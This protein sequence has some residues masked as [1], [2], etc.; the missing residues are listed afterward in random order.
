MRVLHIGWQPYLWLSWLSTILCS[1]V[2]GSHLLLLYIRSQ[3]ICQWTSLMGSRVRD[4]EQSRICRPLN[5]LYI[6]ICCRPK[7][8]KSGLLTGIAG[9]Y[10]IMW[11]KGYC[12]APG[13][14]RLE[15]PR[16]L[17]DRFVGL[18]FAGQRVG[19][20]AYKLDLS[21]SAALRQILPVFR[22]N[23]LRDFRDNGLRQ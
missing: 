19:P 11:D 1:I 10:T 6:S 4:L 5:S 7:R 14:L 18:F 23:L 17:Q 12:W 8:P 13:N 9:R 15:L 2:L 16:K 22:V 21:H 3:P 20:T